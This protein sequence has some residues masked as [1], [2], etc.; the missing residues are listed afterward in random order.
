M[1]VI[2]QNGMAIGAV[3]GYSNYGIPRSWLLAIDEFGCQPAWDNGVMCVVPWFL[4]GAGCLGVTDFSSAFSGNPNTSIYIN[5]LDSTGTNQNA[6]LSQAIGSAGTMTFTQGGSSVTIG[7]DETTFKSNQYTAPYGIYY[8][9]GNGGADTPPYFISAT[10]VFYGFNNAGQGTNSVGGSGEQYFAQP[11]NTQVLTISINLG[12]TPTPTATTAGPTPTPTQVP[13]PT[14]TATSAGPT[15]TPT[16]A[17]IS[18]SI[19][20]VS[21]TEIGACSLTSNNTAY[22]TSGDD[23][24]QIGD[25]VYTNNSGTTTYDAGFYLNG[26]SNVIE[27]DSLGVIIGGPNS[28]C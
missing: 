3:P 5:G 19:S 23:N 24:P 17:L 14:P 26:Y 10:G 12:P 6:F 2:F 13:N 21:G 4:Q 22:S 18:F 28:I 9:D 27:L 7:F 15:P 8:D 20:T 11:S 1:G 16:T 25:T